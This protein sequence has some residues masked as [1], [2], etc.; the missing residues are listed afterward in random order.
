MNRRNFLVASGSAVLGGAAL[1]CNKSSEEVTYP[2]RGLCFEYMN[3]FPKNR[4]RF[5]IWVFENYPK[6]AFLIDKEYMQMHPIPVKN[7]NFKVEMFGSHIRD[8]FYFVFSNGNFTP[9]DIASDSAG[10]RFEDGQYY[11]ENFA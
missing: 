1:A 5:S 10:L 11:V 4:G 9:K 2:N 6:V 3:I 8:D 7:L